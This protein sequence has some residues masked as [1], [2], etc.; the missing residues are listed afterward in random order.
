[1]VDV[2][3]EVLLGSSLIGPHVIEGCSTALCYCSFLETEL[4]FYLKDVS[5][6]TQISMWLQH[7]GAA[8]Q[9]G[10]EVKEFLNKSCGERWI[11]GSGLLA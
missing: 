7:E 5:S 9:F 4:P 8:P 1:L 3:C 10:R 2:L 11:R 6:S